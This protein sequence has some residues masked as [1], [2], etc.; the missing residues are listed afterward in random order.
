MAPDSCWCL[1][2]ARKVR[3]EAQGPKAQN[4]TRQGSQLH[5]ASQGLES[6]QWSRFVLLVWAL[7][8][9]CSA[10]AGYSQRRYVDQIWVGPGDLSLGEESERP[11]E[12]VQTL[13]RSVR[14][15]AR[16]QTWPLPALDLEDTDTRGLC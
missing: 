9:G 13:G 10:V 12:A 6:L 16:L 11:V 4:K 7:G 8:I 2:P 3:D 5:N 15:V 14:L 1:T